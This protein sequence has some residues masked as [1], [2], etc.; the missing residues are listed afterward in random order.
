ME[1][2]SQ[3]LKQMHLTKNEREREVSTPWWGSQNHRLLQTVGLHSC[4]RFWAAIPGHQGCCIP[5]RSPLP[6]N[7]WGCGAGSM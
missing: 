7:T 1:Q 2:R 6:P 3:I 5:L 4:G